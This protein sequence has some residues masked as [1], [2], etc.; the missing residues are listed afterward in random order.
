[1]STPRIHTLAHVAEAEIEVK[2]SRFLARLEP[3]L[4]EDGARA[5]VEAH[6]ATA[7]TGPEEVDDFQNLLGLGV[8]GTINGRPHHVGNRALVSELGLSLGD[9]LERASRHAASTGATQVFVTD[10]DRVLGLV[11]VHDTLKD[12]S[13]AAVQSF[14]E[15]GLTPVMLT[16]DNEHAARSIADQVGITQVHAGVLPSHKL[17][18]VRRLQD[19]G[20]R[21][22]M[23]G[24]GV[25]DA[26]A[27]TRADLGM[28]MGSGTDAAIA[29]SDITLMQPDLQL[30]ADAVSLSRRT[31]GTIKVNLFWAFFYNVIAI[32]VAALGFLNPMVAAAAM[33]FS[34]VSVIGNALRL[35]AQEIS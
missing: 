19:E 8:R 27:L 32:P 2:R 3:V 33:A 28:A 10:E 34:S 17:D 24:D 35:R 22:A 25:N 18:V 26:A 7:T 12:T 15:L 1:M 31:L 9:A 6:R 14:K 11:S 5:V 20:H 13:A 30:A 23:V 4:D 29:A 16:G 21:V